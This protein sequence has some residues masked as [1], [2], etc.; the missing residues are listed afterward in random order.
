MFGLGKKK[1]MQSYASDI[2]S[3]MTQEELKRELNTLENIQ[4]IIDGLKNREM[5]R[6]AINQYL[7]RTMGVGL[8]AYE[9]LRSKVE[10]RLVQM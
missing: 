3:N 8:N 9:I 7:V 6:R 2:V 4:D 10:N 5:G 1:R